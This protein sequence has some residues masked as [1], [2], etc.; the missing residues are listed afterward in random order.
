MK[1]T[2]KDTGKNHQRKRQ[3]EK[4]NENLMQNGKR[5]EFD[6]FN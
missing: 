1:R 3:K 4:G 2:E 6:G 5:N